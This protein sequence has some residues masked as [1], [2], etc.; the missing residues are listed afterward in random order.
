MNMLI[1]SHLSNNLIDRTL[2]ELVVPLRKLNLRE[3]EFVPLKAIIILNPSLYN[4]LLFKLRFLNVSS[5][6][7][8][9]PFSGRSAIHHRLA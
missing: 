1:F 4:M 2:N 7:C 3:E 6:R 9:K 5:F 8:K